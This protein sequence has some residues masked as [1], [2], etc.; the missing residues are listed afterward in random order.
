MQIAFGRREGDFRLED[1]RRRD[2]RGS[3]ESRVSR[4]VLDLFCLFT[5]K[6][7]LAAFKLATMNVG[8]SGA[9]VCNVT[10]DIGNNGLNI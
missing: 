1:G 5:T 7:T 4:L 3:N 10:Q 6:R 9:G 2:G 8:S